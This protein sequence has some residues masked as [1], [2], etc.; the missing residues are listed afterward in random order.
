[1][2]K[3]EVEAVRWYRKAAD[4]G[5]A[6]A[7][8]NL[9][10]CYANGTGVAKDEVEAVRWYRK[11]ADQGD[12]GAQS[13]LASC[14]AYGKGVAK[15]E[16]E[17]CAYWNLSGITFESARKNLFIWERKMSPNARLLGQQRT[18]QLQNEIEGR[19]ESAEE[20]RKAIERAKRNKGA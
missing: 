5:D 18:K 14:Y 4:Q 10:F 9:G 8:S 12:A 2:A 13:N 16:I 11:A 7:Q 3:D 15:D 19:F 17:A 6:G 20:V 1:V